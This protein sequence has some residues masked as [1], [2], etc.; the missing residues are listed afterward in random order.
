MLVTGVSVDKKAADILNILKPRFR[1]IMCTAATHKGTPA[2]EIAEIMRRLNGHSEITIAPT[3]AEAMR[4]SIDIARKKKQRIYVAGGLF[5][6]V[7]Y[8]YAMRG[9][10]PRTLDFF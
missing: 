10:D 1:N 9:N 7:E 2:T 5:L 8:V 6:G 4:S 3:V